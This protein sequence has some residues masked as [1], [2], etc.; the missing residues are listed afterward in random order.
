MIRGMARL[1]LH[2]A[3]LGLGLCVAAGLCAA[4]GCNFVLSIN[5]GP[6][7]DGGAGGG[8]GGQGG[9]S[10]NAGGSGAVGPGGSGGATGGSGGM[11]AMGM[12]PP[13]VFTPGDC[14]AGM[15]TDAE[16]CCVANHSCGGGDCLGGSCQPLTIGGPPMMEE[17][18]GVAVV[19]DLAIWSS[20]YGRTL[21]RTPIDGS[22]PWTTLANVSGNSFVT[23]IAADATDVY[24]VDYGGSTVKR[25]NVESGA[26]TMVTQV[27][28]AEA[29]F[30]GVAVGSDHV[31][32]AMR[33]TGGVYRGAK[34]LSDQGGAELVANPTTPF[35][36]A[37][38]D[39]YVY[40]N[41]T[42][43][44]TISRVPFDLGPLEIVITGGSSLQ[45]LAVDATHI[46]FGS[47]DQ[48]W[49]A[50]K[51]GTDVGIVNLATAVNNAWDI[52]TDDVYV[53]WTGEQNDAIYRA[54]KDGTQ[55]GVIIGTAS[56]PWGL[57]QS[58]DALFWANNST[59]TLIKLAK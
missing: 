26:E 46:Y 1:S 9:E 32:F 17:A 4:A 56:Q 51:T 38:D 58:C 7:G 42:T 48:V 59:Q 50:S 36:V 16:N 53:Y 29:R 52:V 45:G 13:L 14:G 2:G 44:N 23:R 54:S 55:P 43:S 37:L 12:C 40:F 21:Y 25:V 18:I 47:D 30:G 33:G 8:L 28:G 35:D 6:L 27:A 20:G 39:A 10:T 11:G 31:Y 41:D 57:A 24:F 19:G 49:K 22:G 5:E 3:A 15:L 34:N